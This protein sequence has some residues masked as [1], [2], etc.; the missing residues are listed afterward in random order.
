M[1]NLLLFF[2]AMLSP[3]VLNATS[4]LAA[5]VTIDS[6][7][8]A[9]TWAVL[10]RQV[11]EANARACEEFYERY[12]DSR[13]YLQCVERWGGDDGPD[14]AIECFAEW[15][16]LYALGGDHSLLELYKQAWEGHLRQYTE[17]KTVDVEMAREGMYFE[18]FPVTFDW[19]HHGEGLT[20]FIFQGL[21]DPSDALYAK[22]VRRF[23]G[24]YM[25]EDPRAQNYDPKHRI[26]RSLFNGSR[27]PLLRRATALDWAGDPIDVAGRF[28]L[29]HGERS[30]EEMLAHFKDYN[31]I[32][33]DH[34]QNLCA[35]SLATTAYLLT[36]EEKYRQW[37]LRYVDAWVERM[38]ANNG[39]IPTKIGLD[40]TIGASDGKW[41]GGVYGWGFSVEVPQTGEIAHR[42]THHLALVG[43]GNAM[44]LSGDPKY[45]DAW[46][47]QI[48]TVNAA[49][50]QIDGQTMYP[51]MY[52]DDGWYAFGPQPYLSGAQQVYYW[53][54][55]PEDLRRLPRSI[56]HAFSEGLDTQSAE[57]A[58]RGDLKRINS[59]LEAMRADET[60]P[61]SRLADDPLVLNPAT[62]TSLVQLTL[63]GLPPGRTN[64]LLHS[65][66]RYF[67]PAHRRSGLP[68]DVAA[69]V[70]GMTASEITLML[71]NLNDREPRDIVV[72][73]GSYGE[74]QIQRVTIG[75]RARDVEASHFSA[76]LKPGAGA[77]LTI[78]MKRYANQP[79]LWPPWDE[80]RE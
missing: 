64:S 35:T 18:E 1:R 13:G 20:A 24:L 15:P 34:P 33:G 49:A 5:D 45:A 11:L 74:H 58:F 16:L 23:A 7:M 4:A 54:M 21:A 77:Q 30:Y 14:D 38:A 12:V 9:P 65:R 68:A 48:K 79:T 60:T 46:R 41:Y 43:L 36:G 57:N 3:A 67:D 62:A 52:G 25:N 44:L 56:W 53:S 31:D 70:V 50:K 27:G 73:G 71:V 42:N 39:I 76:Q 47:T 78:T 63:G 26:I 19:V 10:E 61:E 29:R 8:P 75:D 72:Q 40:G 66:L 59:Q 69:L 51:S 6:P 32:V 55:K 80:H 2:A 22:R 37:V 28:K 17:A